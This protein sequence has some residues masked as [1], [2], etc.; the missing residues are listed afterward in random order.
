MQMML[1]QLPIQKKE[2]FE[3]SYDGW[4]Q[5]NNFFGKKY[6]EEMNNAVKETIQSLEVCLRCNREEMMQQ[7][8]KSNLEMTMRKQIFKHTDDSHDFRM[9]EIES[10][11]KNNVGL[12]N[13][14]KQRASQLKKS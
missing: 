14:T 3:S 5:H 11:Q 1:H 8:H 9:K 12:S 6:K 7:E 13:F 4:L 2:S 10:V